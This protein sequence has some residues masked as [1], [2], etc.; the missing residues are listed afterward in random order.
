MLDHSRF[1]QVRVVI[2]AAVA[3]GAAARSAQA[4]EAPGEP[5]H[6]HAA[7]SGAVRGGGGKQPTARDAAHSLA[8]KGIMPAEEKFRPDQPVTRGELAVVLVRMIDY[9]ESRGPQ[10]VAHSKSPP[11]VAPRVRA[12]LAALPRRHPAY[13]ALRRLALGGY[14][15]STG[16]DRA[17]F[18]PTRRNIDRPVTAKELTA[19]L[20]GI[21]SRIAEKRTALEHPEILQDQRETVTAPGQHRGA[22]TAPP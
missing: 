17:L 5:G 9:L 12:G 7:P 21:A 6:S 8:A 11:L 14:L 1:S 13:P 4:Q 2:L 3:V 15:L 20:A 22:G 18:L 16:P 19:A 10:K